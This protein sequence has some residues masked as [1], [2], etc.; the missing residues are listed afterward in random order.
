MPYK[1]PEKNKAYFRAYRVTHRE[2][3]RTRRQDWDR[4]KYRNEAIADILRRIDAEAD[5][6]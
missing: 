6:D 3:E 1:D 5:E 4:K 2:R